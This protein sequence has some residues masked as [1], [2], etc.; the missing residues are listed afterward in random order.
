[1][2]CDHRPSPAAADRNRRSA[3]VVG[4]TLEPSSYV[5]KIA[6]GRL[7]SG[8]LA[9]GQA[10]V[11]IDA[12]GEMQP[13]TVG[14]VFVFRNLKRESVEQVHAGNIVAVSGVP[15][16]GIGDTLTCPARPVALPPIK[17]EE[18]TVRMLFRS[19]QPLLRARGP[20]S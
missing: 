16:V 2:R 18:P 15:A 11:H 14:Q 6:V 5:G 13:A 17:V 3:A 12:E 10:I 4:T 19:R 7:S 8:S 9:A 1:M 20:P